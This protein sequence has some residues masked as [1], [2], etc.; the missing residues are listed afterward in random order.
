MSYTIDNLNFDDDLNFGINTTDT[1]SNSPGKILT[2]VDENGRGIILPKGATDEK[3]PNYGLQFQ[4]K[5]L[6]S[7]SYST[8]RYDSSDDNFDIYGKNGWT[9]FTINYLNNTGTY[10]NGANYNIEQNVTRID[11]NDNKM[12]FRTD[13]SGI[14]PVERLVID[15]TTGYVGIGKSDLITD[16]EPSNELDVNGAI[17]CQEL[18]LN[19]TTRLNPAETYNLTSV[20]ITNSNAYNINVSK[21]ETK[22]LTINNF[23]TIKQTLDIYNNVNVNGTLIGNAIYKST[24]FPNEISKSSSDKMYIHDVAI[25]SVGLPKKSSNLSTSAGIYYNTSDNEI[26]NS[27]NTI[28]NI[29][30]DSVTEPPNTFNGTN[31]SYFSFNTIPSITY[32]SDWWGFTLGLTDGNIKCLDHI[33]NSSGESGMNSGGNVHFKISQN[34][35]GTFGFESDSANR[36]G[37]YIYKSGYYYGTVV[38]PLNGSTASTKTFTFGFLKDTYSGSTPLQ[39]IYETYSNFYAKV[40]VSP[41]DDNDVLFKSGSAK[42]TNYQIEGFSSGSSSV[43]PLPTPTTGRVVTQA[44]SNLDINYSYE[45]SFPFLIATDGPHFVS[46]FASAS[47]SD[48]SVHN[49]LRIRFFRYADFDESD[50]ITSTYGS[51]SVANQVPTNQITINTYEVTG[52]YTENVY[53]A[54]GNIYIAVKFTDDGSITFGQNTSVDYLVVG[55]GGSGGVGGGDAGGGGG[56]GAGGLLSGTLLFTANNYDITIGDGGASRAGSTGVGTVGGDS[57]IIG[58][59]L[60]IEADGGGRGGSYNNTGGSG[61]SGGG[62]GGSVRQSG[63]TGKNGG[64][65]TTSQGNDGADGGDQ[66]NSQGTGSG[67]RGYGGGGGGAGGE[68]NLM[69]GGSGVQIDIW[70]GTN[71]WYA[72]GGGGAPGDDGNAT[73]GSTNSIGGKSG[74]HSYSPG[75]AGDGVANTG[76]GG[77]GDRGE[78]GGNSQGESGAGGSGVVVIRF[79]KYPAP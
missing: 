46:F 44:T 15:N 64:V 28:L 29:T 60:T 35:S 77:G 20:T 41:L 58:G 73:S 38:F 78:G 19:G 66:G 51:N 70:D 7:F 52:T 24:V 37:F 57:K 53:P 25:S 17:D 56:G 67:T 69:E 61:G 40:G 2:I 18:Y 11:F 75:D 45:Y 65:G 16:Y 6:G 12:S 9:P 22:N 76:S 5:Y 48:Y 34:G 10:D 42:D 13:P 14:T 21:I 79:L 62:G 33:R 74:N 31:S 3:T 49:G 55:G 8:N 50:F 43:T 36:T 30:D 1:L 59:S 63:S 32:H 72:A 47:G 4:N 26:K 27:S 54:S 23:L 71:E 39:N 68:G